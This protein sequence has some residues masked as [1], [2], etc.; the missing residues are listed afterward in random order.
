MLPRTIEKVPDDVE[1]TSMR[2]I[3]TNAIKRGVRI[4]VMALR[5]LL[6]EGRGDGAITF[7]REL[8]RVIQEAAEHPDTPEF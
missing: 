5:N 8:Q 3:L 2:T 1:K 7:E 4:N 6:S